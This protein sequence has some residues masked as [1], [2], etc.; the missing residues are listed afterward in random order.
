[1]PTVMLYPDATPR[2]WL[3]R[4]IPSRCSW[5][6]LLESHGPTRSLI[7][8]RALDLP[9]ANLADLT[10]SEDSVEDVKAA[11]TEHLSDPSSSHEDLRRLLYRVAHEARQKRIPPERLVMAL[12]VI[13]SSIP[14][15][16]H[17]C[18]LARIEDVKRRFIV[19]SI[20]EYF[21]D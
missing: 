18:D 4:E 1:M 19:T 3:A 11:M 2:S 7:S 21:R 12:K 10:L 6:D 15:T 9:A 16:T 5:R 8:L 14:S 17:D 13:W 20:Q